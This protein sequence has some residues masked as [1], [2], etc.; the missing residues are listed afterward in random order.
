MRFTIAY[1]LL[2]LYLTVMLKPL[3]PL[4]QDAISHSF[5]YAEHI[6]SVHEKYGNNH[7]Q[8]DVSDKNS[9]ENTGKTA[10]SISPENPVPVHIS[11]NEYA[12]CLIFSLISTEKILFIPAC[13]QSVFLLKN[14][15][16]PKFLQQ[17]HFGC[18]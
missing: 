13:L 16:P 7:L 3:V 8:K 15:P 14:I 17:D 6:A 5:N 12:A 4:I 1:Y 9:G 2:L 18:I 10:N 11:A